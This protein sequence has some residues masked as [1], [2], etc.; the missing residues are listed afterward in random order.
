MSGKFRVSDVAKKYGISKRTVKY[1]EEIGILDSHREEGSN[2]RI[3]DNDSLN[4][5]EK[6]L[7]L[8][9]L[10]FTMQQINEVLNLDGMHAKKIFQRKLE[11]IQ[12]EISRANSL[13]RIIK[14]FLEVSDNLGMDNVS[15]YKLLG[16]QIYIHSEIERRINMENNREEK[17]KI[18]IGKSLVLHA[19]AIISAV[20]ELK[21]NLKGKS[22]L[23]IP[24]IR[25]IDSEEIEASEY[26]ILLKSEVKIERSFKV[27][28]L[29]D[30]L[31]LLE[32][33]VEDILLSN[34]SELVG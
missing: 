4:K 7:V 8:R 24:M 14:S 17:I 22:Q 21:A 13:Q 11:E 18:E 19:E 26:R 29:R 33:D 12:N 25:I 3:Y 32:K 2:Y 31:N 23:E 30:S 16:E 20:K 1:Y 9:K 5:L 10:D 27:D 34:L 15:I 28:Y 6:I